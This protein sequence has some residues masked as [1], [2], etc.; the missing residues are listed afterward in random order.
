VERG[1]SWEK[2]LEI[3][4][5]TLDSSDDN[6]ENDTS[7]SPKPQ[8]FYISNQ[9][10]NNHRIAI[11]AIPFIP[12]LPNLSSNEDASK[13]SECLFLAI[14]RPNTGLQVRQETPESLLKKY[15]R[16]NA[17]ILLSENSF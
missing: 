17:L 5:K 2:A 6:Y 14:Y 9:T 4:R 10:K 16:V 7:C 11:L 8:G 1:L 12:A 3:Y 15:K 13:L